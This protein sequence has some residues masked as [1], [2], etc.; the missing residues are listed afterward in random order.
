MFGVASFHFL[1]LVPVGLSAQQGFQVTDVD[2]LSSTV[3][4]DI[5][6]LNLITI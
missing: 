6:T 5:L 2:S 3:W 4:P 1:F